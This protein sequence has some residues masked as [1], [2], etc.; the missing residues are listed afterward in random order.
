MIDVTDPLARLIGNEIGDDRELLAD[1]LQDIVR[2]DPQ[3][4]SFTFLP[5]VRGQLGAKKTILSALLARKCLHLLG[6]RIGESATP[7]DLELVTGVRG[8]TLRPAVKELVDAGLIQ[9]G[10]DG[11]YRV[12]SFALEDVAALLRGGRV[13]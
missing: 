4:L 5:G 10:D 13:R 6:A 11:L 1:I 9:R 2:L 3:R 12:P 8:G 7:K